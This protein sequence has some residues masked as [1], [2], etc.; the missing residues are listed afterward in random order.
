MEAVVRYATAP[1]KVTGDI[2]DSLS[3]RNAKSMGSRKSRDH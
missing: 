3:E 1:A 2:G